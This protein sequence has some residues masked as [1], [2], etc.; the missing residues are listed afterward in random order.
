M[1]HAHRGGGNS[2]AWAQRTG[3][4]A[5]PAP[6]HATARQLRGASGL[7]SARVDCEHR[8]A[9]KRGLRGGVQSASCRTELSGSVQVVALW[10]CKALPTIPHERHAGHAACPPLHRRSCLP[11]SPIRACNTNC[12]PIFGVGWSTNVYKASKQGEALLGKPAVDGSDWVQG[13]RQGRGGDGF[14]MV[15]ASKQGKTLMG[16]NYTEQTSRGQTLIMWD[17]VQAGRQG[18][19]W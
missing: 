5:N 18:R 3:G 1:A 17:W 7:E 13:S 15:Q 4:R 12:V 19:G 6:A 11:L 8:A 14:Q 10:S 2:G 16:W 9:F